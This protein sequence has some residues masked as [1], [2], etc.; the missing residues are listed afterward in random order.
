[1]PASVRARGQLQA[2]RDFFADQRIEIEVR[3]RGEAIDLEMK[4]FGDGFTA[5]EALDQQCGIRQGCRYF[6]EPVL[7]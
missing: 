7:L 3:M 5:D 6:D 4:T 1:M 2:K